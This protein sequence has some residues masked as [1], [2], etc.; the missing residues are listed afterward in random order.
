ML[1]LFTKKI[2]TKIL[3]NFIF[4][5]I[6]LTFYFLPVT[7]NAQNTQT[8]TYTTKNGLPSNSLYRSVIDKRGFLWIATETGLAR[9]DGK[10]FRPYSTVDGLT[11][12]E[13]TD[14]FLDSTGTIWAIPFRR[15][16][17]YYNQIQDKFINENTN[18]ELKKIELNATMR[19][20]VLEFGGVMF[21]NKE[22]DFF[23]YKNNKTVKLSN[24]LLLK[25]IMPT[26]VIE[27]Q[28]DKFVF[29]SEDTVRRVQNNKIDFVAALN[30]TILSSEV[31]K[32]KI[33]LATLNSI[34]EYSVTQN[35]EFNFI[36]EKKFPF[37]IRIF[38]N[39]TKQFAVTSVNGTTYIL[40]KTTLDLVEIVSA[41]DGVPIRNVL[42][43]KDENIW[44][45][46]LDKGL[47]K[48]QKKRISVYDNPSLKQNFNA[49]LK[50]KNLIVGNN[51]GEIFSYDGLYIKKILL[52]KSNT[53]D[54][55]IR[56]MIT[57]KYGIYVAAQSTSLLLDE[58]TLAIKN[59]L[60]LNTGYNKSTK[61]A[62]ALSDTILLL[63]GH[64]YAFKYNLK[65]RQTID[66]V[67]KRVVSLG[68]DKLGNIYIGSND[69]LFLWKD[70]KAEPLTTQQSALSY[71]VNTIATTPE[72]LVWIGLGADSLVVL[73]K[74]KLI[75]TIPLGGILPGNICKV[76]YSN[77]IGE[78]W[79]GT[80]KGINRI[81]YSF[82]NNTLTY[83]STYFGTADGLAGEQV[84]D[85]TIEDSIIYI[86]TNEGVNFMPT[87]LRLPITDI[88]TF[89]TKVEIADIPVELK[90]EYDLT[91][92]QNNFNIEF[93]GVDL[94]GFIPQFE[95]SLND[96]AWQA[97]EK[98]YLKRLSAGTYTI[99]IRA[100][101]RDGLPSKLEAS[102]VFKIANIFWKSGTFWTFFALG[103]FGI[104]LYL[105]HRRNKRK[106]KIALD[107]ITTEKRLTELEMQALKAQINPHF[108][109]NC[110]NSIKGFIY[111]KDYLQADKYLDKFS[112]LMRSTI[113]N[114]DASIISLK[115]E[116]LYLDNYLQLEKLRF[117]EKFDYT[118][119]ADKSIET[120][121]VFVPA[122]L[123]QP[124][125]ENAI[126]HGMRFLE[127]KKGTI[128]ISAKIEG[129]KLICSID[130]NGIGREKASELKSKRHIEYQ[131]KGM[132]ISKRRAELYG[133]EQEI[134]DKKVDYSIADGTTIIVKI[135]LTLK[136]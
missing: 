85:V 79:L 70:K 90:S 61:F 14:L 82:T 88:P 8:I 112:E 72:N 60:K 1:N 42:E 81:N 68:T 38:C 23:I 91:Y 41:I 45:S 125:V 95:F 27:Y 76:L 46:T 44:L 117:D 123:L 102:A 3:S 24:L 17:C 77:K 136:P 29:I 67:S 40:D 130:D 36:K 51:K 122:M 100:I 32:N 93:S 133:I 98:I 105:Q 74:N 124:Y 21:C 69:G 28:Q 20:Y 59:E 5:L 84:N 132:N 71:K 11:D 65:S 97:A 19:P 58:K 107:K 64:A 92:N 115:N 13:I 129:E 126:R 103:T 87:N 127:N 4:C 89:I 119:N 62:F 101:R 113:D 15:S 104:I 30:R 37:E 43:D 34:L 116:I 114:S 53:I 50:N 12:N 54:A 120:E 35:G 31:V 66:S 108:V 25:S 18:P 47:I 99:R 2:A 6:L 80:N 55:W 78:I 134:I 48:V 118:I 10:N 121:S 33:Y 16:P 109:F 111:D 22:R 110:L 39:T 57:T 131:S 73:Y 75:A 26:G 7:I 52:T 128:T 86:A 135:P 56:K 49:I 96:G 83:S 9:F 94:T 63:G 106:Q